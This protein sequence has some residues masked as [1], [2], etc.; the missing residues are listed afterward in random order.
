M[1]KELHIWSYWVLAGPFF[2]GP[3]ILSGSLIRSIVVWS[4]DVTSIG[5]E[6]IL[7]N[8]TLF[9]QGIEDVTVHH[10]RYTQKYIS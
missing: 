7:A 6:E 9:L 5:S 8:M 4:D 2:W 10:D 1:A 3:I